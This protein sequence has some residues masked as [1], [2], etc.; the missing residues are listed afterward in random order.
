[1]QWETPCRAADMNI[2]FGFP[3]GVECIDQGENNEEE[4]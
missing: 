4:V 2:V 3:N 1:M